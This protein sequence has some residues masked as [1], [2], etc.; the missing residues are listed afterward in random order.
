[1]ISPCRCESDSEKVRNL[2]K[3][4]QVRSGGWHHDKRV[5]SLSLPNTGLHAS[6]G[7]ALCTF[8]QSASLQSGGG[9]RKGTHH[10][11]IK[12]FFSLF[13]EISKDTVFLFLKAWLF[14]PK[15]QVVKG[16]GSIQRDH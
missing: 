10:E 13:K 15:G 2:P 14:L 7:S 3:I 16:L 1:M 5:L 8:S 9:K 12:A 6:S 4:S 11:K